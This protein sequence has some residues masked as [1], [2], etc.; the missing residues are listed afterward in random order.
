MLN[1]HAPL[2]R[3]RIDGF[4]LIE[5]MVVL[6]IIAIM[7][8]LAGPTISQQLAN[9]RVRSAADSIV[10]GLNTARAEA[11]R[12]NSA[13]S[14]T[15]NTSGEG[16]AVDQVSP[17]TTIRS[18]GNGESSTLT[19]TST[20]SSRSVTFRPTGIVDTTVTPRLEQ[21]TVESAVPNTNKRQINVLGGGL[22]RMCDPTVTTAGDTRAC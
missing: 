4:T 10:T 14:L 19:I 15:L 21:I 18:R 8:A 17:A 16:W 3:Q 22:I 11:A 7:A 5:L 1:P 13:V 2:Q 6:S 20:T 9:F 12:R